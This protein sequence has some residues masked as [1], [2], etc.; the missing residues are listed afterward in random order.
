MNLQASQSLQSGKAAADGLYFLENF[1]PEE[2][3]ATLQSFIQST[4][5]WRPYKIA[6]QK[7]RYIIELGDW[8]FLTTVMESCI[9]ITPQLKHV[10]KKKHLYFA[11]VTLWRDDYQYYISKH[12]DNT[13]INVAIQIYLNN[14][15]VQVPTIF[16]VDGNDIFPKHKAN[17]GYLM[18]VSKKI[19]HYLWPPVP[20]GNTRYSLYAIWKSTPTEL[21]G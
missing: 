7:N 12:I 1:F 13:E 15:P 16:I 18:D 4:D 21:D 9:K 5:K 11:G 20:E 3:F 17:S 6:N 10:F 14:T 2:D 19:T 8:D